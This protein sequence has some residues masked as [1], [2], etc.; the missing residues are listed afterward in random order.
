MHPI[1]LW[2]VQSIDATARL[3]SVGR[4]TP[5]WPEARG[6]NEA[7]RW[8]A[9]QM[10]VR[11][12]RGEPVPPLWAWHSCGARGRPP[13]DD[14]LEGLTS[15]VERENGFELIEVVVPRRLVLLSFYGPWNRLL[16]GF[17]DAPATFRPEADDRR[18]LFNISR[19]PR[20]PWRNRS[21][22]DVQ[23]TLPYLDAPWVRSSRPWPVRT[24]RA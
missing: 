9:E 18:E 20:C 16:D 22:W 6:W 8:M 23:A 4:L 7:A 17:L 3:R 11:R 24:A 10:R 1:R 21:R 13:D 5:R 19:L 14:V 15:E 2:T 12:I